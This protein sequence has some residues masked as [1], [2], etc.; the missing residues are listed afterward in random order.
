M[1]RQCGGDA[2][3]RQEVDAL[4]ALDERSAGFLEDG[5]SARDLLEATAAPVPG[6]IGPYRPERVLGR[7]GMGI[8]YLARDE[9]DGSEVALKTVD[10]ADAA[11]ASGIRREIR[12]L[13]RVRHEG[14]VEVVAEGVAEGVPWYAMEVVRGASLLDHARG[15]A[16][17]HHGCSSPP[18]QRPPR[19]RW[20]DGLETPWA[21]GRGDLAPAAAGVMEPLLRIVEQLLATVAY[22]HG[23]GIV[24]RDLKPDNIVVRDDGRP[25][26]LDFGLT[27]FLSGSRDSL[28]ARCDDLGTVGYVSPEQAR[29]ELVDARTDLY[30]V[31][32]I[33]YELMT[34]C[35]PFVGDDP[36]DVLRQRYIRDP[37]PPSRSVVGLP[38]ELEEVVLRL[39][40]RD[41]YRR[42]GYAVDVL[43]G[44]AELPRRIPA[45]SA[46]EVARPYL[47]RARLRGR[48]ESLERLTRALD[49]VVHGAGA[50]RIV[51]GES[52]A[53]KTRL[54]LALA[55]AGRERGVPV[56]S[57]ECEAPLP[58][59]AGRA[60]GQ[61]QPFRGVLSEL[62]S[63][64][65]GRDASA[66]SELVDDHGA[67][68]AMFEPALHARGV[69]GS[70]GGA[71]DLPPDLRRRRLFEAMVAALRCL[72]G[73]RPAL[74]VLDDLQWA[75]E[76]SIGLLRHLSEGGGLEGLP[77]LVAGGYRSDE[78]PD[79]AEQLR[80]DRSAALVLDRLDDGAV[81]EMVSDMLAMD[82]APEPLVRYLVEQSEGNPLFV[83]EYLRAM[84]EEGLLIRTRRGRWRVL[85]PDG[86]AAELPIPQS[87]ASIVNRRLASLDGDARRLVDL[88]AV[89]GGEVEMETLERAGD[90]PEERRLDA[91]AR[92]E[93]RDILHAGGGVLRF[94]HHKIREFA[95]ALLS[96]Q[97]R[98]AGHLAA[99]RALAARPRREERLAAIA[100]HWERA[101]DVESA[102]AAYL[103]AA[104]RA[105]ERFALGE[106]ERLFRAHLGLCDRATPESIRARLDLAGKILRPQG[107]NEEAIQIYLLALSEA[108]ST[109]DREAEAVT[110][111]SLGIVHRD[112]GRME[113]AQARYEASLEVARSS[114]QRGVEG[115]V[116]GSLANLHKVL[117]HPDRA[118]AFYEE[119]L[120]IARAGSDLRA[121]AIVLGNLGNLELEQGRSEEASR[122]YEEALRI[123]RRQGSLELEAAVL[124]N[125]GH[126]YL[127]RG[128]RD[129]ARRLYGEALEIHRRT[130][131]RRSEGMV[132]GSLGR[133]SY[134]QDRPREAKELYGE[135]LRIAREVGDRVFEGI[136]LGDLGVLL[137][138]EGRFPEARAHFQQALDIHRAT[139]YRRSVGVTLVNLAALELEE[140]RR[141]RARDLYDEALVIHRE[142][143]E[144]RW[145]G[146][147]H[148]GLAQCAL[149][150]GRTA[151]AL[152]HARAAERAAREV[153]DRGDLASILLLLGHVA[154]AR[155]DDAG[156]SLAQAEQLAREAGFGD[157]RG[158]REGVTVLD[159]AVR[160]RSEGRPLTFGYLAEDLPRHLRT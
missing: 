30:A 140:G 3:L 157:R 43:A 146:R 77:L 133:V 105:L 97:D 134:M 93:S 33:L 60:S 23:E 31:G 27:Q 57:G 82:P 10:V 100:S 136:A 101:G 17:R 147:A 2:A 139:G 116:L 45:A 52:G 79:L 95:Y 98:R 36:L 109:E 59:G 42:T 129:E 16:A 122:A 96:E 138:D 158:V 1:D 156:A 130:G 137:R 99:A 142:V 121:E 153:D 53:G 81:E 20:W 149:W 143:R 132:L 160:A 48:G 71:A 15:L 6:A 62:A 35:P 152:E 4:L 88:A 9:R 120:V 126:V 68:L 151:D 76:L 80:L 58:L 92:L 21:R 84:V 22:L 128:L 12:A 86:P 38:H 13:L 37:M 66:V 51:G 54:L 73:A 103:E 123:H 50:L 49:L 113:E 114:G 131:D 5:P 65:H 107:R 46:P 75:D 32:C 150:D 69:A 154:L 34:G 70:D 155:G 148:H 63:R 94:G 72:T 110:L 159:R 108:R 91:L 115:L 14:I 117:G 89:L 106:A 40:A 119:A 67:L 26:L 135:S 127:A 111:R 55:A 125:L 39:L 25:V 141:G 19:G 83:A 41:P 64:L 90:L 7:G 145:L 8:V 85:G 144:R 74:L 11:L 29:G 56:V 47:Y 78:S 124:G 18:G 104:R 87:L 102:R 61:L 28:A 44:L 112:T 24:H 118:R